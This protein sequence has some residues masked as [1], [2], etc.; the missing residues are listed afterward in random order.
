MMKVILTKLK[1]KGHCSEY[2]ALILPWI[3]IIM[4]IMITI[5]TMKIT[6]IQYLFAR[7]LKGVL[8]L[9]KLGSKYKGGTELER[10]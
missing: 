8:G 4:V 3:M 10:T 7:S 6:I 5:I 1:W 9:Q 2:H